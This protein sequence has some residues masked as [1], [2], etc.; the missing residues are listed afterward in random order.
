MILFYSI[1][2]F[3]WAFFIA[4][5]AIPSI[6]QV[7]HKKQLLDIPSDRRL[8]SENTPRLGGL[9]IFAGFISS[10]MLF[11]EINHSVQ[12]LIAA[13]IVIFFIGLKDDM[14]SV[15]AFKKFFVQI[16]ATS[17]IVFL[18]DVRI[19]NFQGVMGITA[20]PEG[21]EYL[22]TLIVVLGITNAFNLIDGLDGLAG[23]ITV[24]TCCIY[25]GVFF[26]MGGQSSN[27]ELLI[28]FCLMGGVVAFLKY[29][30][31]K[32]QIFMGDTGSLICGFIIAF[33][34][35]KVVMLPSIETGIDI[36]LPVL[37][38]APIILPVADTLRVFTL[39]LLDGHSPFAP[40]NNHLHHRLSQL[41]IAPITIVLLACIYTLV[42]TI[43]F[44][45]IFKIG[46]TWL[47]AGMF[48]LVFLVMFAIELYYRSK[49]KLC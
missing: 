48:V 1:L 41:G 9:A 43:L 45:F 27:S 23:M 39:R 8:H 30:I 32:A 2:T 33:L 42:N 49:I 16:L 44:V 19:V 6:I 47:I 12:K 4:L 34:A 46:V 28:C 37:A 40:D 26:F 38:I 14:V 15:S 3:F 5:F 24:L 29:N 17:I 31:Y 36:P 35:I 21:F 25:A 7:A 11:G 22:F 20:L 13:T 18:G 10:L